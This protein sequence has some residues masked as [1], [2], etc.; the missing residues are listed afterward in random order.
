MCILLNM[1][2]IIIIYR[3]INIK[4]MELQVIKDNV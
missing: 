4:T 1:K 3:V 2:Y